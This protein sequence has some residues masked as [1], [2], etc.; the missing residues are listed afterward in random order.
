MHQKKAEMVSNFDPRLCAL[1]TDYFIISDIFQQMGVEFKLKIFWKN[2][3][4]A[5][6]NFLSVS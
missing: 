6:K 2:I 5:Y 3:T 4:R 1:F